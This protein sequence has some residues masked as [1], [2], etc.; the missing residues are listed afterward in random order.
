MSFSELHQR[1]SYQAKDNSH[2]EEPRVESTKRG[3]DTLA[4]SI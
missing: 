4:Q 3:I 2:P 1:H